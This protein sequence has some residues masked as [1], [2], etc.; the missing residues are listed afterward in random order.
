MASSA[1]PPSIREPLSEMLV[2]IWFDHPSTIGQLRKK[3]IMKKVSHLH[4]VEE[5]EIVRIL[6]EKS[7][8]VP[9]ALKVEA[10][11]AKL[12][13]QLEEVDRCLVD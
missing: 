5:L 9:L 7:N 6:D 8:E 10:R 4:W 2:S 13:T 12:V 11:G 1:P 3:K